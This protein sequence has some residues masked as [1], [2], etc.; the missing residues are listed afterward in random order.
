MSTAK[1]LL[2]ANR[3]EMS[4][5]DGRGSSLVLGLGYLAVPKCRPIVDYFRG[6]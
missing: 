4:W 5:V 2:W 3:M 6:L 1:G